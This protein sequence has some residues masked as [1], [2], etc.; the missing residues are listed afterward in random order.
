MKRRRQ[1]GINPS[2]ILMF[3]RDHRDKGHAVPLPSPEGLVGPGLIAPR[4]PEAEPAME[5]D[6][7]GRIYCI[8]C[9]G[10]GE[11]VERPRADQKRMIRIETSTCRHCSGSGVVGACEKKEDHLWLSLSGP[12]TICGHCKVSGLKL[13]AKGPQQLIDPPNP[14]NTPN[15]PPGG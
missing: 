10:H 2:Q 15:S 11:I 8:H 4:T 14:H 7:S 12:A 3:G 5:P 6:T 13:K 1:Y 9:G